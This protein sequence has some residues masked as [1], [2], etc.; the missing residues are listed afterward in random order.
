MTPELRARFEKA[1]NVGAAEYIPAE[2]VTFR[3]D[4]S[5][6]EIT[7]VYFVHV[8]YRPEQVWC[9]RVIDGAGVAYDLTP[10]DP[11]YVAAMARAKA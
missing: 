2:G 6:D 4:N 7:D 1:I 11:L 5:I 9:H 10:D 3:F 8:Y